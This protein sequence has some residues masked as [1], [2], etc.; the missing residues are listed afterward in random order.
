MK[1]FLLTLTAIALLANTGCIFR[2]DQN[3]AGN[4]DRPGYALH[5]DEHPAGVDHG[6]FPG[7]MDHET[8][9]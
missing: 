2:G 4:Q 5:D 7:D 6:E 9:R 1:L 8:G 3:H